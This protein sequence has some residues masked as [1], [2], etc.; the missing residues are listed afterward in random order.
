M[1]SSTTTT[2]N[3]TSAPNRKA[4]PAAISVRR[5][6]G[7]TVLGVVAAIGIILA[8]TM[9]GGSA[10]SLF[11]GRSLLIVLGG[12]FAILAIS[13]P[14]SQLASAARECLSIFAP[15]GVDSVAEIHRVLRLAVKARRNGLNAIEDSLRAVAN[16]P[17]LHRALAL[18]LDGLKPTEIETVL[19]HDNRTSVGRLRAAAGAFARASEIAPA[20]G[21]I[22]TLYGLVQMLG[23]LNTPSEIGPG[24]A[25]ALLTTLYGVALAHMVF[26]PVAA[27]LNT[28]TEEEE[29]LQTIYTLA[30]VSIAARDNPRKLE[31]EINALMPPALRTKHFD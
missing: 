21:L 11:D 27:K 8:L 10:S 4:K 6:D 14:G 23:T 3:G 16:A 18:A 20:M 5:L 24:M 17:F 12:T 30:A 15:Y 28:R 9:S 1:T 25:L 22:G 26:A 7:A 19:A 2:A 29:L 31:A 13:C